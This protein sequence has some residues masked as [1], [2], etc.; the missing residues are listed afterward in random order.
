MLVYGDPQF[1]IPARILLDRFTGSSGSAQSLDDL[2][3]ALIHAGQFEQAIADAMPGSPSWPAETVALAMKLTDALAAGF[4]ARWENADPARSHDA[5]ALRLRLQQLF[6]G[7]AMRD[8]VLTVKIPEGFAFY[9]LFP[10]QYAAATRKWCAE[11][12]ALNI[13]V[14]GLRSIGTSLSAVV[15]ATLLRRGREARR[16]TVRPGGPPFARQVEIAPTELQGID[17]ALVVDEGPGISG[18]S[19]AAAA[20]ALEEAEIGHIS[21]L[22]GHSGD[23]GTAAT[24]EIRQRWKQTPRYV[25]PLVE[26]TWSE[27][28]LTQALADRTVELDP[29]HRPIDDVEELTGGE[30]RRRAFAS[31]HDWPAVAPRFERTKF[32]CRR[33]QGPSVLWKFAGLHTEPDGQAALHTAVSRLRARAQAGFTQAP[34]ATHAGFIALPWIEGERL[35]RADGQNF[36]M[37]GHIGT[38]LAHCAGP[39]LDRSE[40]REALARLAEMVYWNTREAMDESSA[41]AA[42]ARAGQVANLPTVPG[43][44]DGRL[45]PHEWIKTSEGKILKMDAEG[46]E[47]DHTLI[48]KQPLLWDVAAAIVEWDFAAREI[49]ELQG[50]LRRAGINLDPAASDFYRIAYSAFQLGRMTLSAGENPD[51]REKARL[52]R[53][54]AFY[55]THLADC[56]RTRSE[57]KEISTTDH[58]V[59]M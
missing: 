34:L 38:Y 35:S 36:G 18:S 50:P 7:P 5:G 32:L 25:V 23:P 6:A 13:L 8:A 31:E 28:S 54:I 42:R 29:L 57:L 17:A 21:F 1:Q 30:W 47:S 11:N 53:A 40:Q 33:A 3:T 39:V 12:E 24:P 43:A 52:N 4:C 46:H 9:T 45:A 58:A 55:R 48:G 27:R 51:A 2:R 20:R 41:R 16:L 10:E 44:P 37:A 14:T 15:T 49:A 26:I 59:P 19:M 22:P 56:L